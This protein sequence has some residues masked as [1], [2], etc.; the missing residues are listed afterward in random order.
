MAV[1]WFAMLLILSLR[2]FASSRAG[3]ELARKKLLRDAFSGLRDAGSD[4]FYEKA[5]DYIYLRLNAGGDDLAVAARI[6]SS[7][8]PPEFKASLHR[9][10]ERHGETK[11]AAG[12]APPP[13]VEE[14]QAVISI[15]KELEAR[16]EK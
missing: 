2:R 5:R 3:R 12:G 1:A 4:E 10:I 6:D 8:L 7:S 15:L 14:R 9:V 16:Y 13:P 11:Y